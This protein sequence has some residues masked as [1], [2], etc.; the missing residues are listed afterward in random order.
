[1]PNA[2]GLLIY[3]LI[4]AIVVGVGYYIIA[5]IIPPPIQK[6]AFAVFYIVLAIFVIYFLMSLVGGVSFPRLR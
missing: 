5:N 2:I 6:I 1:M 3:L 4:F